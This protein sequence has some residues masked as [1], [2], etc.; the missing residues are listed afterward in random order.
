VIQAR[1]EDPTP[2]IIGLLVL[3]LLKQFQR[4]LLKGA[5]VTL[6]ANKSKVRVL[7]I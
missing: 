1:V 6:A 4:E 7:P 2:E 3:Q 5:I